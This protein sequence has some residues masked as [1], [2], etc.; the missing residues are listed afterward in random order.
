MQ[1]QTVNRKNAI[2]LKMSKASYLEGFKTEEFIVH[3]L[4]ID[5]SVSRDHVI[6]TDL[7]S[8]IRP[9]SYSSWIPVVTLDRIY[10]L[11]WLK[12]RPSPSIL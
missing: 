4:N 10:W 7:F 11:I 2:G 12:F 3:K 9:A 6:Y 5:F 1:M 8:D